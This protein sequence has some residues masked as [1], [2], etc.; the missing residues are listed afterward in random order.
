MDNIKE[1]IDSMLH[2]NMEIIVNPET[3]KEMIGTKTDLPY[4]L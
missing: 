2:E 3:L 1:K 4:F